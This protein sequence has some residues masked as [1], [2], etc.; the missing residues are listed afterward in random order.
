MSDAD[1]FIEALRRLEDDADAEPLVELFADDAVCDNVAAARGLRGRSGARQF[2]SQD[3]ALFGEVH[4]EFRNVIVGEDRVALEWT[5]TGTARDGDPV[6][7]DGVSVLELSDGRIVRF[8]A[9]FDPSAL[10]RQAT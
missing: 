2:W 4:S 1:A 8:K 7:F 9:Y 5:R 6:E 10:G 3:R